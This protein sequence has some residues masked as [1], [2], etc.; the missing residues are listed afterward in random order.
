MNKSLFKALTTSILF[1]I[2][3]AQNNQYS[4]PFLSQRFNQNLPQQQQNLLVTTFNG[5]RFPQNQ[6][7]RQYI[8]IEKQIN[9]S[10]VNL[11]QQQLSLQQYGQLKQ[12]VQKPFSLSR[13]TMQQQK[14]SDIFSQQ[15]IK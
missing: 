12:I 11:S 14:D 9:P 7:Q 4:Q 5:Q 10:F 6:S 3:S 15:T 8:H 2:I 13:Q 1:I